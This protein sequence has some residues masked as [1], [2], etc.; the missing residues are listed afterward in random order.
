MDPAVQ[1]G[2]RLRDALDAALHHLGL[3]ADAA[4]QVGEH[5]AAV[6]LH[7]LQAGVALQDSAQHQAQRRQAVVDHQAHHGGHG[8]VARFG[9]PWRHA[10][11][12]DHGDAELRDAGVDR[13]QGAVVHGAGA[14]VGVEHDAAQ[15]QLAGR[16][17][18]LRDRRVRAL[19]RQAGQP[20][21]ALP[22][23]GARLGQLV[24]AHPRGFHGQLRLQQ[25]RA[26][27]VHAHHADV[28]AGSVHVA[29]LARHAVVLQVEPERLRVA[30]GDGVVP[31]PAR[32][33]G[34]SGVARQRLGIAGGKQVALAVD[35]HGG[36][37]LRCRPAGVNVVRLRDFYAMRNE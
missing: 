35:L 34:R 10:R 16:A 5:A 19:P 1:L 7:D 31:G 26:G 30:V 6:R 9:G 24:V 4:P 13:L 23:A 11:M 29:Q 8:V 3:V 36:R 15:I 18:Q 20:H 21:Q 33:R 17:V 12:Q 25:L 28:D 22:V 14:H 27:H 37:S 2:G 32:G